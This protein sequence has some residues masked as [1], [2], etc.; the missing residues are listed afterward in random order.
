MLRIILDVIITLGV[1]AFWILVCIA[2]GH[3]L[4]SMVRF[5]AR[6]EYHALDSERR[7]RH[8]VERERERIDREHQ[9]QMRRLRAVVDKW[10]WRAVLRATFSLPG[11]C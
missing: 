3:L 10:G 6:S 11:C 5:T 9:E 8:R 4:E 2:I 7:E 1:V